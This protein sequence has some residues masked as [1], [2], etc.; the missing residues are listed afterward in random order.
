[1]MCL[2]FIGAC[3]D[4]N[5]TTPT[6]EE[7]TFIN[8][9]D[10]SSL[11]EISATNAMYFDA[12]GVAIDLVQHLKAKGINTVRVRLWVNPENEHSSLQEVQTFAAEIREAHMDL[13]LSLHYSDTWADPSQQAA[14]ALWTNLA[15]ATLLDSVEAYTRV[16]MQKLQPDYIQIGNEINNGIL[17]PFGQIEQRAQFMEIL[18]RASTTIRSEQSETKI[19]LHYAGYAQADWFYEQVKEI[20]YDII[21]LSYYPIW[22]GKS[23][24]DLTA[25]MNALST[26][27]EKSIV[28][29]ETAYPFTLEWNDYTHNIVGLDDQLILPNYP[30]SPQGQAE[31]LGELKRSIE[32]IPNGLGMAY[33][34][35]ELIAWKGP[36]ATDASPWENQALFDFEHKALPAIDAM[37]E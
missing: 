4:Q 13:W 11:P 16:I 7:P 18:N 8:A 10:L 6:A 20:D 5:E 1:M 27:F 30:A 36:S 28:L 19:M 12:N 15:F 21:A 32:Q 35:G 3:E 9:L 33:W 23:L 14:P 29:A 26:K 17:Y 22:H 2:S 34:G 31:F 25:E 37:T 24:L